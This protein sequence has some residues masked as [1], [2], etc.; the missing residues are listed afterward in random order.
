MICLYCN[1]II[2]CNEDYNNVANLDMANVNYTLDSHWISCFDCNVRYA[3]DNNNKILFWDVV[4]KGNTIN[5]SLMIMFS[6][7][8]FLAFTQGVYLLNSRLNTSLKI[9][10]EPYLYMTLEQ[11]KNKFNKYLALI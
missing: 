5:C 3:A 9:P 2:Q 8:D 6:V 10:L 1:K 4:L 11:L 7:C